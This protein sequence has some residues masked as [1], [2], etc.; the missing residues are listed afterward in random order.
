MSAKDSNCEYNNR[1]LFIGE[2]KCYF[3]F[4]YLMP[5]PNCFILFNSESCVIFIQ[6]QLHI[7]LSENIFSICTNNNYRLKISIVCYSNMSP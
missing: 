5:I 3:Y 7:T 6:N 4:R 2:R 1:Y